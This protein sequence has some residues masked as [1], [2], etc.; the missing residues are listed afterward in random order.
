MQL[1]GCAPGCCPEE[2]EVGL[3]AGRLPF[4]P[5]PGDMDFLEFA[6][7]EG[8]SLGVWGGLDVSEPGSVVSAGISKQ[9][10]QEMALQQESQGS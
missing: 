7:G 6:L 4:A 9:L 5:F 2:E 3:S 10:L 1:V 8:G